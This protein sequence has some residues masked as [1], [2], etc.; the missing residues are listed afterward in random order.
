MAIKPL[1][2]SISFED[3]IRDA[4]FMLDRLES[5]GKS[6]LVDTSMSSAFGADKRCFRD[7]IVSVYHSEERAK[8]IIEGY[9]FFIEI[10]KK[11]NCY[12][13]PEITRELR[14]FHRVL[15]D[16]KKW[17]NDKQL[18]TKEV[19]NFARFLIQS[20]YLLNKKAYEVSRKKELEIDD[21]VYDSYVEM[22]K[23]FNKT[24]NLKMDLRSESQKGKCSGEENCTDE[25]I[26]AAMFWA[27]QCYDEKVVVLTADNDFRHL[28]K[29]VLEVFSSDYFS[30][31]NRDF[32]RTVKKHSPEIVFMTNSG[33]VLYTRYKLP[34]KLKGYSYLYRPQLQSNLNLVTRVKE[35]W[36]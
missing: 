27:A 33:K 18:L 17:I 2:Q 29:C 20:M 12:T 4:R 15:R 3:S 22:I 21:R 13:L 36:S 5:E 32:I 24:W 26:T 34:E 35:L 6:V 8:I 7:G 1:E 23:L 11:D 10:L 28:I 9:K 14:N 16:H 31:Y 19:K 30:D 25:K